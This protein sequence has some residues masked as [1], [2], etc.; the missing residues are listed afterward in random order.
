MN[1]WFGGTIYTMQQEGHTVEAILEQDGIIVDV[2]GFADLQGRAQHFIDLKGNV[3]YPGFVDSH[4]HIIGYGEKLKNL[5]AS[6]ITSKDE[7][8]AALQQR[9]NALEKDDWLVAIGYNEGASE[10]LVFPTIEELDALNCHIVIKRSCHHLIMVNHLAL[11]YAKIDETTVSPAGG[12]IEQKDGALT[13]ILKDSALYLVVNHMPTTTQSYVDDAL[14][15]SIASL[16]SFGIVGGHSED[17]SY[18]GHPSVPLQ[19]YESIVKSK[20]FKAHL[21]QHH[22]AWDALREM[23]FTPSTWL[24]LGAM[25][26]FIDGAFG[27]RTAALLSPYADDPMNSGLFIHSQEDLV[28]LVRKARA[29]QATIAVHVIGDAAIATI[30]E[31]IEQYLPLAG[32]KDRIIHCSLVNDEL[33]E[34]LA[35][36]PIIVDVQPQ[37]I[38]SDMSILQTRLG[39]ERL[40]CAHPIQS[41]LTRGIICAGGSDAPIEHP[42]PLHG[43]YAAIT[44]QKIGETQVFNTA[45]CISRYEAVEL[46]TTAPAKVIDKAHIRGQIAAGFE[47]DFTI[48]NGDLFTVDVEQI[49]HLQVVKTVVHGQTVYG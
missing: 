4:L 7:L 48:L 15:K 3:L 21:L 45:E 8:M 34:R 40:N 27:G 47:A 29:A 9:A 17:L 32:Q 1:L 41:L 13:G 6:Q 22:E 42:N 12:V 25:K 24:E 2:G 37:F 18:Y 28:Q 30:V 49:P 46:Y 31:L 11:A 38:Q 20:N 36:L 35:A 26:I 44:R 43:I 33:L 5:D 19:S 16:H 10:Q 23:D 39:D 14:Q